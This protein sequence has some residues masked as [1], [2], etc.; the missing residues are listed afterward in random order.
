MHML[1]YGGVGPLKNKRCRSF[2]GAMGECSRLDAS[3]LTGGR[4]LCKSVV[5]IK[6]IGLFFKCVDGL[7]I[8][9]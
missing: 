7:Y 3:V 5:G 4:F 1:G 8:F 6:R 9:I 2:I